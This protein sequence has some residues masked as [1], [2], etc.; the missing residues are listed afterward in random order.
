MTG[1]RFL[2]LF[3]DQ[4]MA[5]RFDRI[6]E[7]LLIVLLTFMPLALGVVH[8]WSEQVVIIL[9]AAISLVFLLKLVVARGTTF[10]WSWAYVPVAVFILVAV[11]Q[12]VPLPSSL[13][14]VASP[15]TA[16]LKT[17]LLGDLPN[18]D[19]VLSSMTLSFYPRATK[20]DLR[21]VLAVA[22][23]FVVV[24]NVYR[25]SERIKRLLAAIAVLGGGMALLALA[26]N[27]AGNG[28]IYWVVPTYYDQ[29]YS[30]AFVNHSH[31]GQF[32]SL[33]IGAALGLLLVT[34]HEAFSRHRITP[35][36][37]A[38]YLSS[39]AGRVTKI[40]AGMMVLGIATVFISLTRGG[41]ISMLIAAGFTTLMLSWHQ[42]LRGPA[43]IVVLLALGSFICIL[44]V[45]FD[46]VYDRLATL[47]DFHQA[48][49]G[50]WQIIKDV[51][52]AWTKFP[53]FGAGLGT[54]EVVYPM[55]DR[56]TMTALAMHAENEY[57]QAAEET[58]LVG[59][60]A[61]GSFAAIV[62]MR[63]GRNI[64]KA[65]IPI[66][67]AAYGLG[68]GLLAVLVHSLSDF[69][70]HLPANAMLSAVF[71][72][73]LV[74]LSTVDRQG[75]RHLAGPS[76]R[77]AGRAWRLAILLVTAGVWVWAIRGANHARIAEA[78][79][80]KA[81][82]AEH[83][84]T[85]NDWQGP[86]QAYDYLFTHALNAARWEPD[87]IKYQH[88]LGVYKWL[89]LTSYIDP[90]TQQLRPE[91]VPWARQ[92]VEELHQARPLCPTF[93][94][95][96]CVTGEIERFV[97]GDPNGAERI[98]KGYRL[99]PCDATACFVAAEVDAEEGQL[100]GAYEKLARAVQLDGQYFRR[101]VRLCVE[102]LGRGDLALQLAGNDAGQLGYVARLLTSSGKG[103]A[104]TVS[105]AEAPAGAGRDQQFVQEAEEKA[106]ERL[107][108]TCEAPDAPASAH[109]SLADLYSQRNNLEA[110]IRHCRRAVQLDYGQFYWHYMLATLLARV[111]RIDEARHEA[112]ICLRLREDYAPA[113]KLIEE[114]AVRPLT[115]EPPLSSGQ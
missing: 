14:S 58:G 66:H 99:A 79:W 51:A 89:S 88:W 109:A 10:V 28:K 104:P 22:A 2:S 75:K 29:A 25:Q 8:A 113:K 110:A 3:A 67:S 92:I 43:W 105:T 27:V 77:T 24:V 50:R 78:N 26:Q 47:R 55:F 42:S 100:T 4:P 20:H 19:D 38:D 93:G 30:G 59:L 83:H 61:L 94:A 36:R 102:N 91:A 72:A 46:Q 115:A 87:N 74:T 49:G 98:R 31:Y 16:A 85:A 11:L 69:G 103:L 44:Y 17:D 68:F 34:L 82:V 48:Q 33:S 90:N 39:P 6:I 71:C 114:L 23:V 52:L 64:R 81:L 97:L 41:I 65:S 54:H 80:N 107:K 35:A 60:L 56:S 1:R 18:A 101:A 76:T 21:L 70:Q 45:G 13:I 5:E 84:L 112:R 53:V 111:D 12:L 15:H 95:L 7:I 96:Y 73:L 40:L 32:M 108:A 106:F 37:V 63:Y 9:A 57:A 62:W 86:A